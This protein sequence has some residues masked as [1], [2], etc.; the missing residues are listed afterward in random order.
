[1]YRI[2]SFIYKR[3][4]AFAGILILLLFI[5]IFALKN[6]KISNRLDIWFPEN[7]KELKGY[8]DFL[9]N[10][11]NDET[12][13]IA[14]KS[15]SPILSEKNLKS[16]TDIINRLEKI[17]Y[18]CKP[19]SILSPIL[20]KD[21]KEM[22]LSKDSL[23]TVI[24]TPMKKMSIIEGKRDV[25]MAEIKNIL[26][27]SPFEYHIA[28]VTAVYN[29]LNRITQEN[30]SIFVILIFIYIFLLS[31]IILKNL[32]ITLLTSLSVL[33]TI[34]ILMGIMSVLRVE[35]NMITSMLP[36]L[37]LIY[38][39][40][41]IIYIS[42][43]LRLNKKDIHTLTHIAIPCFFTSL[44]TFLG[45]L[46]LVSS[47]IPCIKQLGI[48][49][50]IGVILEFFVTITLYTIFLDRLFLSGKAPITLKRFHSFEDRI[51]KKR[52]MVIM[53]TVV[54]S[55]ILLN[56]MKFLR[57]DTY[58]IGM[59]TKNNIVKKDSEWIQ[60]HIGYYLPL[61]LL[62]KSENFEQAQKVIQRFQKIAKE[63]YNYN[64]ISIF[65]LN[66]ESILNQPVSFEQN[67]LDLDKNLFRVTVFI[68]MSS[69]AKVENIINKLT[70][71]FRKISNMEIRPSGYLPLYVRLIKYLQT[72]QMVS[73]PISFLTVFITIIIIFGLKFGLSSI[74]PNI[75]PVIAVLGIMGYL[76]IPLDVGTIIIT[77]I[78]L[79]VVVDDTIHFLY[80]KR[81]KGIYNIRD[82]MLM[83][84]ISLSTGFILLIFAKLTTIIY[85]GIFSTIAI[86]FAYYGD[87]I[88]LPAIFLRKK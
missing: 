12:V 62:V 2:I 73:F 65:D 39:L 24:F 15:H 85:F 83:T 53:L 3:K 20:S 27:A 32:K 50:G 77:P 30:V 25:I 8:K 46:S 14:L 23:A 70:S 79:G 74:L 26:R 88:L 4:R 76:H 86:L 17:K 58:T 57:F 75:L 81:H 7:E 44:T 13:V 29:E 64:S 56:G 9:K 55:L 6:I 1:M 54:L 48:F 35:L 19:T 11:G 69:A 37:I 34:I 71:A 67:Y 33:F 87:S 38:G 51:T 63:K 28:G 60:K 40:S 43:T 49:G 18:I 22:L 61:E 84:S 52:G 45:Y 41:D 59:F 80:F 66:L 5:S 36:V 47:R 72:S 10:F 68:P 16:L 82:P 42:Y 31:G 78:I 21:I